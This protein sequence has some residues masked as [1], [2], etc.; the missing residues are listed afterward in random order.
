MNRRK[1]TRFGAR[2]QKAVRLERWIMAHVMVAAHS[3]PPHLC[4]LPRPPSEGEVSTRCLAERGEE[5]PAGSDSL[6]LGRGDSTTALSRIEPRNWG[7]VI[8]TPPSAAAEFAR[9]RHRVGTMNLR[10]LGS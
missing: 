2:K 10:T 7:M 4:P 8:G 5:T 6:S 9:S 1:P 3:N